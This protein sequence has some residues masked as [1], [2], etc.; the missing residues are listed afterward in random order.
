MAQLEIMEKYSSYSYKL[1][2]GF[3]L[4]LNSYNGVIADAWI[5]IGPT[6]I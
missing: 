6:T 4:D 5:Y 2:D 1:T 3:N